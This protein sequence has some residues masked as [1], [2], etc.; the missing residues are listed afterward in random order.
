MKRIRLVDNS[1]PTAKSATLAGDNAG[2]GPKHFEW[3]RNDDQSG[4]TF[5]TDQCL[6]LALEDK[7]PKK[8]AWLLEPPEIS[9][10][11]YELAFGEL[12][13]VFNYILTWNMDYLL[14]P[15]GDWNHHRLFY[16]FGGSWIKG[17]QL[18]PKTKLCSIIVSEKTKTEG[19]RLRHEIVKRFGDRVD[20][21]GRGYNPID[22]KLE[23]LRDYQY[24]IV[25]E[26]VRRD[27]WFTEKLIDCF[28]TGT[29]PIY[30]G[31]PRIGEFFGNI[32][33]FL[34]IDG[35]S[36]QLQLLGEHDYDYI[37]IV[38]NLEKA[39]QYQCAEDWIYEHYP[40]LFEVA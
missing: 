20:V 32:P 16:P 38:N 2:L 34:T 3:V 1:F 15:C 27:Y 25:V 24:S 39:R 10:S 7:S 22:S 13:K 26:N 12:Y 28:A 31:C 5:F 35:L 37:D 21:F 9:N 17:W 29:I 33:S 23:A 18:Y 19:H 6:H 36:T 11:H 40:F 14:E 8:I 4:V 30:W